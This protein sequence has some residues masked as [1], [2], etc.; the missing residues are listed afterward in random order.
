MFF[1]SFRWFCS[2]LAIVLLSACTSTSDDGS[3]D[4]VSSDTG[5]TVT[6]TGEQVQD[7][8]RAKGSGYAYLLDGEEDHSL[9]RLE[10]EGTLVPRDGY[11][12]YG[13]LMGGSDGYKLMGP[14][15][16]NVTEIEYEFELGVNAL[17][18]GYREFKVFQHDSEPISPGVGEPVWDGALSGESLDLVRGLIGDS[19][20]TNEGSLRATETAVEEILAAAESAIDGFTD[21]ATFHA[22]AEAISNAITGV[23]ED[24]DNNGSVE[25]LE[26]LDKGLVG[27]GSHVE[28]ILEDLTASFEA[29][30]G[31]EAEDYVREALDNAYDCIQ[32]VE[33]YALRAQQYAGICTVCAA[34]GSCESTMNKTVTQLGLA[35]NGE[36]SN[37][38][39]VISAEQD[40]GTIECTIE[41]VSRLVGFPVNTSN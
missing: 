16:V 22:N 14:I 32:R 28:T 3:K 1:F 31:L 19:S 33:S 24:V 4:S 21:L 36:D 8:W 10:V 27:D 12:Y 20:G 35:L 29:F 6:D 7:T 41:F 38:D 11:A 34:Q 40:E 5:P 26:S 23:S 18:Q 9:F 37:D 13:W 15:P 39:G 2:V 25:T 30:G 17:A